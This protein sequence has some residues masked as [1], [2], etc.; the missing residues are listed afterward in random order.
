MQGYRTTPSIVTFTDKE[1]QEVG[2][3]AA[4][5]SLNRPGSTISNSKRFIGRDY[6]EAAVQSIIGKHP[7]RIKKRKDGGVA[8][9]VEQQNGECIEINPEEVGAKILE[10]MKGIA[11]DFLGE[12]VTDAV[13]TVP[14][15]F[16]HAQRQATEDAAHIAGL[17]VL[18][19]INEPTAAA[20]AYGLGSNQLLHKDEQNV[21]VYDLGGGTFDISVLCITKDS[22]EVLATCGDSALG[23]EDFNLKLLQFCKAQMLRQQNVD[24]S[25]NR[26]AEK[27]LLAACEKAKQDLSA[28]KI[29]TTKIQ[30]ENLIDGKD[31]RVM[32]S[33]ARF[34][35]DCAQLFT[36]TINHVTDALKDAKLTKAEID[37]V[38][39][40]GGST[41][42]PKIQQL[43][44][45]FFDGKQLNKSVNP[46]EVVACGAAIQ[47]AILT[48]VKDQAIQ[49]MVLMD[50]TPLS[51]GINIVGGRTSVVV[52]RNFTIP[53]KK[54]KLFV[55]IEDNQTSV[56]FKVVQGKCSQFA[57]CAHVQLSCKENQ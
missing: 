56:L 3:D 51:L 25:G 1:H 47:A 15:Y 45:G 36:S 12:E 40:V 30:V 27:R 6:E 23:G 55:T 48:G 19:I 22:I 29:V 8:F 38:I 20:L 31:F 14:A 52:G 54:S 9:D 41:R 46:D 26:R 4:I 53:L 13:I 2:L 37:E 35:A 44:A 34:E 43:L 39:L 57:H 7:F 17:N 11:E 49:A 50:V 42:I 21:L 10:E 32:L 28:D 16:T 33:R 24:I 18:R 5:H